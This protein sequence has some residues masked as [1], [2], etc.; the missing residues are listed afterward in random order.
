MKKGEVGNWDRGI[1]GNGKTGGEIS[2][3]GVRIVI[4]RYSICHFTESSIRGH[5]IWDNTLRHV[6]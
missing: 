5:G 2:F 3:F 6:G 4:L 1:G